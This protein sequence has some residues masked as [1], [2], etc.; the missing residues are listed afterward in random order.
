MELK[1]QVLV[2][3]LHAAIEYGSK[4]GADEVI[5]WIERVSN[6]HINDRI[7]LYIVQI[8]HRSWKSNG[9]AYF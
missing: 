2:C 3:S 1:A 7:L 4:K 9:F 6:K 8:V 5:R